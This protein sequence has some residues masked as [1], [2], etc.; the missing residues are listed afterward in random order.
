M[1]V[2]FGAPYRIGNTSLTE[3]EHKTLWALMARRRLSRDDMFELIWP[4]PDDEPE[5][6]QGVVWLLHRDLRRK[7]ESAGWTVVHSRFPEGWTLQ[8]AA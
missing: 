2:S 1:N 5:Y 8:E 6:S 4:D 7:L 3:R